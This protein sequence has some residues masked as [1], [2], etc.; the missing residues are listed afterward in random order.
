MQ[1]VW[2]L[3]GEAL[4]KDLC[5][6]SRLSLM[7]PASLLAIGFNLAVPCCFDRVERL[8]VRRESSLRWMQW[9]KFCQFS[10]ENCSDSDNK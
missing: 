8:D 4:L 3:I 10:K 1:G 7:L 2:C 6:I 9:R 5:T